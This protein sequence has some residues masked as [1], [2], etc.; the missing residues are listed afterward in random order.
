M[1]TGQRRSWFKR[2][3][4]QEVLQDILI[5]VA[6]AF[7]GHEVYAKWKEWWDK[8]HTPNSSSVASPEHA[9]PA[10]YQFAD[11]LAKFAKFNGQGE[12]NIREFMEYLRVHHPDR[13]KPFLQDV[14]STGSTEEDH[15]NYLQ[16]LA[17]LPSHEE[18]LQYLNDTGYA[19]APAH[20]PGHF[21][22]MLGDCRNELTD[23]GAWCESQRLRPESQFHNR[24]GNDRR[25][26]I[27]M[28]FGKPAPRSRS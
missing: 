20:T 10:N 15:I 18:R 1:V 9:K 26:Y 21:E 6:I 12:K 13:L 24:Y 7:V 8:S 28:F 4:G 5:D 22:K 3:I 23:I 17:S 11:I 27:R 25:K 16:H 14:T 19:Q 2:L